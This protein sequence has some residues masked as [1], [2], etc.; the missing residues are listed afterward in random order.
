MLKEQERNKK[1][2]KRP[3]SLLV[4]IPGNMKYVYVLTTFVQ[5]REAS[6]GLLTLD[7]G[8]LRRGGNANRAAA[9]LRAVHGR[10]RLVPLLL[11]AEPDEAEAL[12]RARHGVGHHLGAEHRGILVQKGCLELRVGHLGREVPNE[13]RVFGGLLYALPAGAPVQPVAK[14]GPLCEGGDEQRGN[15]DSLRAA[16][17]LGGDLTQL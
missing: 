7:A 14:G 13:N 3:G 5:R 6:A 12:R 11:V 4:Y 10:Q 9:A 1:Q 8:S 16:G 17:V 15:E 2:K